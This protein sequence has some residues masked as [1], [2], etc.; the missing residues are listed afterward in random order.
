MKIQYFCLSL[1]VLGCN[2]YELKNV[3]EGVNPGENGIVPGTDKQEC[4][5]PEQEDYLP[6]RYMDCT[7]EPEI[8]T[9]S[10]ILEWT[11]DDNT[12]DE[13]YN[14]VEAPP[15]AINLNDDNGDG[16]VDEN[17]TPDIIFPAFRKNKF[18][19][20]GH[21][22]AISG[23]T[24]E[25]LFIAYDEEYPFWGISGVAA[26]DIDGD[27]SPDI[28]ATTK[29]GVMR[30]DPQGNMVW[31]SDFDTRSGGDAVISLADLDG[32]GL[33]E[34][35]LGGT[36]L[37]S[38]GSIRWQRPDYHSNAKKYFGAFAADIDLD[39]VQEVITSGS[40]FRHDGTLVWEAE[41]VVG[42]PAIGDLDGDTSPEIVSTSD[43]SITVL[44]EEGQLVWSYEY[45]ARSGPPT[46][47]DFDG[48]GAA[49]VG[50]A[51][52]E[53]YIVLNGDG[54]L[55]W[56]H[57]IQEASSG[58]TGSSVFDFE[59]DGAAEVVYA[60]EETLWIL[61]GATGQVELAWNEHDSGTRFEYPTIVDIDKDGSAE[62][63]LPGGR[64]ADFGLRVIGSD[65]DSW[66]PAR[67]IWNQY[68]YSITNIDDDG[69]IPSYPYPSWLHWNNFR[70]GNS[71]T[72][73]GL[74]L[75]DL[76]L[77]DPSACLYSCGQGLIDIYIPIENTGLRNIEEEITVYIQSPD[78][79]VETDTLSILEEQE[80]YWSGPYSFTK[81]EVER[82]IFIFLD[83][84]DMIEECRENNN[85]LIFDEFMCAD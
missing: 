23:Q 29:H 74:S 15:I 2:E 54:T 47:A 34:I 39:G 24:Q 16:Q 9:F 84:Q 57:P 71:E 55:L 63:L 85:Q 82:G 31:H 5:E 60:D 30:L 28:F 19:G 53:D 56:A 43:G 73:V 25:P 13:E 14:V 61:D 59:G 42:F 12:V 58:M 80:I 4:L 69:R 37:N 62:I 11:W 7:A 6:N 1:L 68:A 18:R 27:S 8:G 17:D 52:K 76:Q 77:G 3:P 32:D 40:V 70:A 65:D 33:S 83:E 79:T 22:I 10:P 26:G 67:N 78:G 21:L 66:A 35:I 64:D 44:N 75:P 81:E 38:D 36:V 48:D 51:S 50:V 45:G 41:G 46:I 20:E 72:R 49:E